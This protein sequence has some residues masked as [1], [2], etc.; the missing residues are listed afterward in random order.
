MKKEEMFAKLKRKKK[1]LKKIGQSV[2][3]YGGRS[4]LRIIFQNVHLWWVA[5]VGDYGAAVF[6]TDQM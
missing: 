3:V 6:G 2:C 4:I 1:S 5:F